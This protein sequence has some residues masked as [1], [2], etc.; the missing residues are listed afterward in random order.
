MGR[1]IKINT[2]SEM[3]TSRGIIKVK[4]NTYDGENINNVYIRKIFR[5]SFGQKKEM[6][7]CDEDKIV[8]VNHL[9]NKLQELQNFFLKYIKIFEKIDELNLNQKETWKYIVDINNFL[10]ECTPSNDVITQEILDKENGDIG[11]IIKLYIGEQK[12]I[13][14]MKETI[15]IVHRFHIKIYDINYKLLETIAKKI[16]LL[17]E[18]KKMI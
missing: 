7:I 11:D 14:Y 3:K 10:Y 1:H 12:T 6:D 16:Y 5:K 2:I 17:E 13:N 8:I 9:K 18:G 4:T 15:K